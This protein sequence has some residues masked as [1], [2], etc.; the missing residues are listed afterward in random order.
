MAISSGP[1][2]A[3]AGRGNEERLNLVGRLMAFVRQMDMLMSDDTIPDILAQRFLEGHYE[4]PVRKRRNR[5]ATRRL[6]LEA[7][8]PPPRQMLIEPLSLVEIGNI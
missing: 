1:A 3:A 2:S 5:R 8:G 6:K 4:R 7:A